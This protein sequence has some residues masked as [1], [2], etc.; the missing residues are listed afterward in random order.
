LTVTTPLLTQFN[1]PPP[2]EKPGQP[3]DI[4]ALEARNINN[5]KRLSHVSSQ[6]QVQL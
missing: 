5:E 3:Y 6:V 1:M 2:L 4:I